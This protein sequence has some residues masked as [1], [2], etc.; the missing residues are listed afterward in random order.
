MLLVLDCTAPAK[1]YRFVCRERLWWGVFLIR[2]DIEKTEPRKA[3]V[4][5]ILAA[6]IHCVLDLYS[7]LSGKRDIFCYCC[8]RHAC[9]TPWWWHQNDFIVLARKLQWTNWL[10]HW[11]Y[12]PSYCFVKEKLYCAW[13]ILGWPFWVNWRAYVL[14]TMTSS[15]TS[16]LC[17]SA[18]INLWQIQRFENFH[19]S[20]WVE[21]G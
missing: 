6:C 10:L 9:R 5:A 2:C 8:N 21:Q 18:N 7:D 16:T 1:S 4:K 12:L 17:S 19:F 15:V 3:N 20:S 14:L 11:S 13:R